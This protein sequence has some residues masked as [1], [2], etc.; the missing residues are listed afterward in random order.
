[1]ITGF[2]TDIN[3]EGVT[4]HVQTEDKGV[5][6]PL[7]LSL[8]Y[9]GGTIL[10]SKRSPY[11]DLLIEKF[12]EKILEERLN[13]Q[14]N[15]ICAAIRAGRVEDL[16]KMTKK[17]ASL[18]QKNGVKSEKV[19]SETFIAPIQNEFVEKNFQPDEKFVSGPPQE[20]LQTPPLEKSTFNPPAEFNQ[21]SPEQIEEIIKEGTSPIPKPNFSAENLNLKVPDYLT[22]EK[23]NPPLPNPPIQEYVREYSESQIPK[24]SEEPVWDIPI[25]EDVTIVEED[26]F[27]GSAIYEEAIILPPDAV[28]I[29]GD[30]EQF[31]SLL[32]NELKVKILGEN[33]FASGDRKNVNILVCRGDENTSVANASVM[34]KVIGAEFR[35][36]IFHAKA[37]GNGV[38]TVFLKLPN[39]R[40]GRA[41]ILIRAMVEGEETELRRAIT[42]E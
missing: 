37:D 2:N 33:S 1:V 8:V 4:Y 6:T 34:V 26:E 31:E 23:N 41:A 9:Q 5:K 30:L 19:K 35:P 24:P 25:I 7:I 16:K 14:H 36:M 29:V 20:T 39:F 10:A 42:P 38:A 3:Y 27:D 17:A 15:L 22:D 18:N 28:E 12:D 40:S 11:E 32:D 21:N 13:R